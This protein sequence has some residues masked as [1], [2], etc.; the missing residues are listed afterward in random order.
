MPWALVFATKEE[1]E[2]I[3]EMA[4]KVNDI[5]KEYLLKANIELVDF[6]LEFGKT[7]QGEIVLADENFTGY[8]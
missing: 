8:M 3:K 4:F 6:K 5:L 7:N 1:I 2:T